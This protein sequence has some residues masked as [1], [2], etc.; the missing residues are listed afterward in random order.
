M[1][2]TACDRFI[3]FLSRQG[4]S[5]FHQQNWESFVKSSDSR[6]SAF[7]H[8]QKNYSARHLY[9]EH[10][11]PSAPD[12]LHWS[13]TSTRPEGFVATRSKGT[14]PISLSTM[15]LCQTTLR[16]LSTLNL[17]AQLSDRIYTLS[18]DLVQIGDLV[19]TT[20]EVWWHVKF[21]LQRTEL[22]PEPRDGL[23]APIKLWKFMRR[24]TNFLDA[25]LPPNA[26]RW[27]SMF[28]SGLCFEPF[29]DHSQPQWKTTPPQPA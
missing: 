5:R 6:A 26:F 2:Q 21:T 25:S 20:I 28:V 14:F 16:H 24:A 8:F 4:L 10:L 19:C 11:P 27:S 15:L 23:I 13:Q 18:P 7:T 1:A 12:S 9:E 29:R 17:R 3:H 22:E